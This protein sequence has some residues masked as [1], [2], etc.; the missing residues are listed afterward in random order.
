MPSRISSEQA[1][2]IG[3]PA[4]V[5]SYGTAPLVST[6]PRSAYRE[7][8]DGL[9]A[10]AVLAVIV[11]HIDPSY[12]PGGFLGVDIFFV[13]SGFVVTGSLLHAPQ[14]SACEYFSAFYARRLKR[15]TPALALFV[16][17]TALLVPLLMGIDTPNDD[18]QL[19]YSSAQLS[20]IG[21]ANILYAL[22]EATYWDTTLSRLDNNPFL[23]CWSLGVWRSSSTSSSLGCCSRSIPARCSRAS[24]A[25]RV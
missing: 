2:L 16:T 23:H 20:T 18:L 24:P 5:S 15:L 4:T 12:L 7:D 19:V 11:F 9:R 21:G 10:I 3:A 8:I 6:R 17:L 14:P 13:I 1:A 22:Q 25:A